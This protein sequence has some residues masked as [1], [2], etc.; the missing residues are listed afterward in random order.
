MPRIQLPQG[1]PTIQDQIPG[2]DLQTRSLGVEG[3]A[4]ADFGRAVQGF[5]AELLQKRSEA[6]TADYAFSNEQADKLAIKE[7]G[8]NLKLNTQPG[9]Q[10][11]S[12]KM[13]SFIKDRSDL[14]EQN[15][16]TEQARLAYVAKTDALHSS[17]MLEAS[18]YENKR[19]AESYI[20][21]IAAGIDTNQRIFLD[22][23]DPSKYK[24]TVDGI[25]QQIDSQTGTLFDENQATQYKQKASQ[26]LS[27]S[28]IKG[29]ANQGNYGA[30]LKLLDSKNGESDVAKG[31]TGE[32]KS[33]LETK[34]LEMQKTKTE[35]NVKLLNENIK[36]FQYSAVHNG[37][38]DQNQLS[39]ILGSLNTVSTL[40]PEERSRITDTLKTVVAASGEMQKLN[41]MSS[42]QLLNY[43]P[44]IDT[45]STFNV[46]NR[47]E[48]AASLTTYRDQLIK[49]R[50]NDPLAVV[51]ADNPQLKSLAAQAQSGDPS[52]GK[53]YLDQAMAAQSQLG[54]AKPRVTTKQDASFNAQQLQAAP[55]A[56]AADVVLT[57]L[58]AQYGDYLPKALDEM[59][60]DSSGVTHDYVVASYMPNQQSRINAIDNIQRQ[61]DINKN[62]TESFHSPPD[63]KTPIN[64]VSADL[65]QAVILRTNSADDLGA[66]NAFTKQIELETKKTLA[67]NPGLSPTKAV[68]QAYDNIVSKNYDMVPSARSTIMIPKQV[69]GAFS[70]PKAVENFV[71]LNSNQDA[72]KNL[73]V[74]VPKSYKNPDDWYNFAADKTRW[75]TNS[76]LTGIQLVYDS[77]TSGR[78]LPL[79][80]SKGKVIEKSFKDIKLNAGQL[81]Q[82]QAD[83][84]KINVNTATKDGMLGKF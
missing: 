37:T 43:K 83:F 15:A 84:Q 58:K 3:N 13:A 62:F 46:A 34:L 25:H 8:D 68:N 22:A 65:K 78:T 32:Q 76:S 67:V 40:K 80:D 57:K 10:D 53:D 39:K 47:A 72:L 7:Y 35:T 56:A 44:N 29:M 30:A 4:V 6:Q 55:S 61:K 26:E 75:V 66:Y 36:D 49:K 60:K 11:Y 5:G 77:P 9:T 70:D 81:Q 63:L 45:K 54:V 1:R 16:P 64:Q 18:S 73:D 51:Q 19:N 14:N 71:S 82:Q 27:M 33:T 59:A 50:E 69:N 79:T 12:T 23:P 24:E 2:A 20:N 52:I 74:I 38:V 41:S 31:L 17:S 42:D 48:I 28:I 21:N